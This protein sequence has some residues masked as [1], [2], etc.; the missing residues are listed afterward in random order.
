MGVYLYQEAGRANPA[1]TSSKARISL[2]SRTFLPSHFRTKSRGL[3]ATEAS[4]DRMG[5]D[6][7][8]ECWGQSQ[9]GLGAQ[10]SINTTLSSRLSSWQ[11]PWAE[12]PPTKTWDGMGTRRERIGVPYAPK[13]TVAPLPLCSDSDGSSLPSDST[14]R[15]EG[16][17]RKSNFLIESSKA[18]M[19]CFSEAVSFP[20]SK[21]FKQE[22]CIRRSDP[23]EWLN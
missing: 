11:P 21:V 16:H 19:G 12:G 18:Q 20:S 8:C 7:F 4:P 10:W 5:E 6:Q 17:I 3:G 15:W 1:V 23:H 14:D 22:S 13:L 2:V 9:V